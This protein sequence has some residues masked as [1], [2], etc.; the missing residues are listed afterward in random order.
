MIATRSIRIA[1]TVCCLLVVLSDGR[2]VVVNAQVATGAIYGGVTDPAGAVVQN[3]TITATNEASGVARTVTSDSAGHYEI[4]QLRVGTYTIR[5]EYQGFKAH[6]VTGVIVAVTESTRVDVEFEVGGITEGIVVTANAVAAE[7][8]DS[9]VGGVIEQRRI[10]EMPLNG[11]N[12]LQLSYFIPG[13]TVNYQTVSIKG[14]PTNVP[15]GVGILPFVNGMRNVSNAVLIDGALNN[16]PV[17]NTAAVVPVPDAIEEFKIQTNLYTPEFGQG[18]GSVINIV[19]KSGGKLFHGSAYYFGRNDVLDARNPFLAEKPALRRHQF[20]ASIGGPV[21]SSKLPNTFFFAN[22]EG[23]RLVQG[24]VL[25]S[26]VPTM[27]E[28]AGDFSASPVP[29]RSPIP[30]CIEGNV[31]QPGCR[32]SLAFSLISRLWPEPNAGVDRFQAAPNMTLNRD[33]VMVKLDHNLKD[34]SISGRYVIDDGLE[35]DPTADSSLAV[36]AGL[37]GVTG[38]PVTQPSRF[39]NLVVSDTFVVSSR[40]VN[41]LRFSYLRSTFGNNLLAGPRDDPAALGFTFPVLSFPSMPSVIVTGLAPAGTP[42]HKD[43]HKQN[44][45]FI[46]ADSFSTERGAHSLRFGGEIRRTLSDVL[47]GANTAGQYSFSGILTGNGF[48]DYLIG[49]PLFFLQADGDN[50]RN[51]RSTSYG[52]FFQDSYR[53]RSN[54]VLNYGLRWDVF[55]PFGDPRIEEIGHPR[56]ASFIPGVKSTYDPLLPTGVV[57]CG[58]DAGLPKACVSTKKGDFSPRFGLA[59]DMFGDGKTSLRMGYGIYY[60][61]SVLEAVINYNDG[62]PAIRPAIVPFLPG[63]GT[64]ADPFRGQSPFVA[65]LEFPIDTTLSLSPALVNR[66]QTTPYAQQWNL[67]LERQLPGSM[68]LQVGYVGTKGTHLTGGVNVGQACLASPANPCN[69]A[70]TNTAFNLTQRRPYAGLGN[71]MLVSTVFNSSY[72]GL[73]TSLTR[74]AGKG[75]TYQISYTWSKSIDQNSRPDRDF[76]ISGQAEPQN[77]FD[78]RAERGLSAFDARH[79]LV[80]NVLYPLPFGQNSKTAVKHLIANWQLMGI[81]TLQTGQPFT[82]WDSSGPSATGS[83]GDRPNLLC[84]PN[85]PSDQRS[86]IRWFDTSC[87]QKLAV[88]A[89]FGNAGRNILTSDRVAA[90]DF[91]VLK[92]FPISESKRIE[93]RAEAF[94]LF[95][96]P[97]FAAPVNDIANSAFGHVL[98]TSVP[99]RNIQFAL[100]FIF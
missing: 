37:T 78:L 35:T 99:E 98:Q 59:W 16:D 31:I 5:A 58:I 21:S 46:F 93:F 42:R 85:L 19:T 26:L 24:V 54:L 79:R 95:N 28:R 67:T 15:G 56:I 94:N 70:T 1:M 4:T 49:A 72:H 87:F 27:A 91:S 81:A 83:T 66:D 47:I 50:E 53:A 57:M 38:F 52:V 2:S 45:S 82:V 51:Y 100:K 44:D 90:F 71:V 17:L 76:N 29:L 39:Q 13:V 34:H 30:G 9:T 65:P 11:R 74:R 63:V 36:T 18:A 41:I 8:R 25:N 86:T 40:S 3:A 68:L 97:V 7:T 14:S 96:H 75:P 48:A 43:A 6:T 10:A 92:S 62:T 23:L 60:D 61:S 88:G 77:N 80:V 20:G 73:Q 64:F 32:D 69:G 33:Q 89:G 55:G 12:F 84:D 22:Y